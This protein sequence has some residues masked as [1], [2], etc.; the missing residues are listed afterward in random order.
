MIYEPTSLHPLPPS[1]CEVHATTYD[2]RPGSRS[3]REHRADDG[4]PYIL[5]N[6]EGSTSVRD[7][8]LTLLERSAWADL[9]TGYFSL[10]GFTL[11]APALETLSE[12]RLLFG[13]SRIT[14]E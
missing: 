6:R 13:R 9:A 8:L 14:D 3:I 7:A 1:H 4:I 2:Y 12:F 5:D 11:L 10:S